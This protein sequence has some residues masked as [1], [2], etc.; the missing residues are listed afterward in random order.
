MPRNLSNPLRC[1]HLYRILDTLDRYGPLYL[2]ELWELSGVFSAVYYS[3]VEENLLKLGLVE[4]HE[5]GRKIIANLTEKGKK[6]L[7]ALREIGLEKIMDGTDVT[8][9]KKLKPI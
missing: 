9:V 5:K 8:T 3:S 7:E 4:Y 1:E 6:L 2:S